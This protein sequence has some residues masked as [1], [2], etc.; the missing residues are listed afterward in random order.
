MAKCDACECG[1]HARCIMPSWCDCD[2]E[3]DGAGV[4]NPS[5]ALFGATVASPEEIAAIAE[6]FDRSAATV[7]KLVQRMHD[8]LTPAERAILE[9]RFPKG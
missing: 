5:G 2:H 1:D 4:A 8:N 3:A 6:S 7:H 9:K